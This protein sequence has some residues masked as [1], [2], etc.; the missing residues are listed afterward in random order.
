MQ[1]HNDVTNCS[2]CPLFKLIRLKTFKHTWLVKRSVI[3]ANLISTSSILFN[4]LGVTF[5]NLRLYPER[6][7]HRSTVS[8]ALPVSIRHNAHL[9]NTLIVQ[10]LVI[11]MLSRHRLT[12]NALLSWSDAVDI[13]RISLY[14]YRE[15]RT[16]A[17]RLKKINKTKP[18]CVTLNL[19][20]L[21][22]T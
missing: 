22:W 10:A 9:P 21:L 4:S 18:A 13:P 15:I 1:E 6:N 12:A 5:K 17:D 19:I 20:D 2:K 11:L 16:L 8:L 14:R 7:T 3:K